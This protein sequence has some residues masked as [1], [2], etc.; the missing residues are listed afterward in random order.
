MRDITS[1]NQVIQYM[2][3]IESSK[4][5]YEH[6][7]NNIGYAEEGLKQLESVLDSIGSSLDDKAIDDLRSAISGTSLTSI[8]D[9]IENLLSDFELL[10]THFVNT[11]L[12]ACLKN[13]S[14][15]LE[16]EDILARINQLI[17]VA[18]DPDTHDN[19]KTSIDNLASTLV[20]VLEDANFDVHGDYKSKLANVTDSLEGC[21]YRLRGTSQLVSIV[22]SSFPEG[23]E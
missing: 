10:S 9:E 19:V 7:V 16:D 15:V 6:I 5:L 23:D 14:D 13:D 11:L 12:P 1:Y 3:C 22:R 4:R 20:D 21:I 2:S 8:Q 17:D 18:F